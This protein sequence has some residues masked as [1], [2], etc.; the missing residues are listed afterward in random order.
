MAGPLVFHPVH[1]L[2]DEGLG[3]HRPGLKLRDAALAGIEQGVPV[4]RPHRVAVRAGDVVC[5]DFQLR[6]GVH[7]GAIGQH[8]GVVAHPGVGLV[9]AF[10]DDDLALKHAAGL[11]ADDALGE[12]GRHA[13]DAAVGDDGGQVGGALVGQQVDAAPRVSV[14]GASAAL[15]ARSISA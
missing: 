3:Q 7:L 10:S 14:V 8:Q 13:I 15:G 6:L 4:Q 11:I 9:R 1:D 5:V 12:L 2:A